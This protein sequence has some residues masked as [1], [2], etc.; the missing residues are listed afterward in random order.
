MFYKLLGVVVIFVG[1][2]IATNLMGELLND[3]IGR[4]FTGLSV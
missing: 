1:V 4:F 3:T 2:F